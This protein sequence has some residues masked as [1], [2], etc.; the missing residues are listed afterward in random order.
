MVSTQPKNIPILDSEKDWL[1]W[2]EYIFII[3]DEYGVKQY[4]K[5]DTL[6]PGLLVAPVRPTPEMIK[7][8]VPRPLGEA[9]PTAYSDL[10][11]YEREQLR[12]VNVEYD[13]DKR[14]YRTHRGYC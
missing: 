8:S 4:I 13:Y 2:S 6:N 5:P 7:C 14:I 12:W 10:D 11:A 9:R 3:A 1:P